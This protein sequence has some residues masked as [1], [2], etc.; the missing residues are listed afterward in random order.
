MKKLIYIGTLL[1]LLAG[2]G[3]R[4]FIDVNN[5][6]NRPTDVQEA[7]ILAPVELTI[8]HKLMA[9]RDGF[10]PILA[11]HY[12]QVVCLNQPVPNEGTY[13]L[14]NGSVNGDWNTVYVTC[15]N[16]LKN[17]NA[18]AE[19]SGNYNYAGIA[20]VLSAFCLATASDW[21]GDVPYSDAL[22]GG[23]NFTPTYN[24]QEVIYD[25]VQALLDRGIA[26]IS[27]N[28]GLTPGGDDNFYEGDMGQWKKLA[29]T[30]KARYYMHLTKAP[31]HTA[32]A[33]ADLALQA[34]EN[35]MTSNDDD[36]KYKYPGGSGTENQWYWVFDPV[37]TLIL[38]SS[39]VDTLKT[40]NDPRLEK[41][42]APAQ[43]TGLYTGRAIGTIDVGNLQ[44][45]SVPSDFYRAPGSSNYVFNYSEAL[46]LKAEATLIKSGYTAAQPFYKAG[47]E[48]H[49]TKLG[50]DLT[51]DGPRNYMAARGTLTAGM[52]LQR[53]IE[54]KFI[55]NFLSFENWND[56]RR[57]G[58]PVI[59]R[60][61]N[62]VA[63]VSGIPRRLLY[64][65]IEITSNPQSQQGAKMDERV[66]WDAQ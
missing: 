40:R 28:A 36:L 52:A 49:M 41:M 10:A 14:V 35:G 29:Y 31:G 12:M 57:T 15:L 25:S 51:G 2:T 64:P 18:K 65:Q 66:W 13:L 27:K 54:E 7:L 11:Q 53:I 23:D 44:N 56:W 58:F 16:N 47:V 62:A 43:N 24:S 61:P 59:S 1:T 21:W 45:Y 50:L 22:Q 63:T 19:A 37:S 17:L 46:F 20:K 4:K 32:T 60:V 26:D 3:C 42:I 30:L 9:G 8:A 34:L 38:S 6:P 55:A 5:D 33:Q 48:S 39:I